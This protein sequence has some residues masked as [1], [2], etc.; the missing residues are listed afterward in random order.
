MLQQQVT[1]TTDTLLNLIR[2]RGAEPH[3]VLAGTPTWYSEEAQRAEDE[4]ANAE[5]A[6]YGLMG[7]RGM[8]SGLAATLD[9]VAHPRVEYYAWINGGYDGKA[10]DY[11]VL[12]GSA[13]GEAFVLGRNPRHEGVVLASV[14][15]SELLAGFLEQIPKLA[16]GRGSPIA[17]PRSELDGGRSSSTA[18]E[19]GYTVLRSGQ[20][21]A[22]SKD[23]EELRRLLKL[24]R[25][26]GGSLYVAARGRGGTRQRVDRP[27]NYIDTT[28]G[29][30]LTE[31]VPGSGET[32]IS[33]TPATPQ[34]LAEKLRAAYAALSPDAVGEETPQTFRV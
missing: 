3:T 4:Q 25:L 28:E 1:L 11:T 26:G 22:G 17:V 9:A 34:L 29:R 2:R 12:A 6:K 8:D 10:V 31:E 24:R 33:F 14:R 21:S 32:L 23:A 7:P 20:A 15:P 5:L 18:Q 13:G 27:L 19:E 30:W 16:P